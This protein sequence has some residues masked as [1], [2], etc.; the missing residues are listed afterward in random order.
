MLDAVSE[1]IVCGSPADGL[2]WWSAGLRHV[3][4]AD[5]ADPDGPAGVL[6]DHDVARALVAFDRPDGDKP[7]EVLARRLAAA[8]IECFRVVLPRD[9]T[10]AEVAAEAGPATAPEVLG[11]LLRAATWLGPGTPPR[12]RPP[13]PSPTKDAPRPARPDTTGPDTASRDTAPAGTT[14][15]EPT[16]PDTNTSAESSAGVVEPELVS[17]MPTVSLDVVMDGTEL[18][19]SAGDRRWRVRGLER[20]S[21]FDVLRVNVLVGRADPELGEPSGSRTA[22]P[23]LERCEQLPRFLFVHEMGDGRLFSFFVI[24]GAGAAFLLI[25]SLVGD[26][27]Q[28]STFAAEYRR[29][30]RLF[31]GVILAVAVLGAAVAAAMS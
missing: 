22:W 13:S 19:A 20:V 21:S 18:R 1:V 16:P 24:L 30:V 26:D 5:P 12:R 17:P 4:A 25:T 10:V 23:L 15:P 7:A 2:V 28:V 31:S 6:E 8:D 27:A 3:I 11:R 29:G 14:R 9:A